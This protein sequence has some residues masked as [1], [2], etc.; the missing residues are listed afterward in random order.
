MKKKMGQNIPDLYHR[1]MKSKNKQKGKY[2]FLWYRERIMM[3][4]AEYEKE[5]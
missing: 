4:R 1:G 2:H 5:A 3:K